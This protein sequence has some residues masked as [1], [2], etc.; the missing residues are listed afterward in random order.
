MAIEIYLLI[1]ILLLGYLAH[2]VRRFKP[3]SKYPDKDYHP[4]RTTQMAARPFAALM[5]AEHISGF[6]YAVDKIS[7]LR[8]STDQIVS[9]LTSD[10]ILT[11]EEFDSLIIIDNTLNNL[12][13]KVR[14]RQKEMRR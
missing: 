8:D 3:K 12:V 7:S 6:N 2:A 5:N 14:I 1:I 4:G 10:P 11:N 9:H 13:R